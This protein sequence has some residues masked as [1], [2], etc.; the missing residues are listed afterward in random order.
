MRW[1]LPGNL[2]YGNIVKTVSVEN[3]LKE[4]KPDFNCSFWLYTIYI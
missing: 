4:T 3:S 2:Q 1:E